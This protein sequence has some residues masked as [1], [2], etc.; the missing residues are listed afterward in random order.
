MTSK[1][2]TSKKFS[3]TTNANFTIPK[4]KLVSFPGLSNSSYA[5]SYVE[6]KSLS[7][8]YG[9]HLTGVDPTAGIYTFQDVNKDGNYGSEDYIASWNL[10][11]KFYGGMSN[12]INYQN[13]ELSFF[14]EFKKQIGFN[15]NNYPIYN[16]SPGSMYNLPVIMLQ[17]WQR[18]G[19]HANI[20]Q[21]TES[22]TP[23]LDAQYI[24]SISDGRFS[25]ASYVR[26]KNVWL[27][28]N[29]SKFLKDKLHLEN[30]RI[31]LAGQNL[32]T[33]TGYQGSDPETQSLFI[34]PSGSL[35]P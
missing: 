27:A 17:R 13:W 9:F 21:F 18:P 24:F 23:A 1:N 31:Y 12:D 26:L 11:P 25:D 10:D 32:L 19:D 16:F 6:G 35:H 4:N 14:I 34:L 2:F 20:Q 33:I 28:Y 7:T 30:F 29:F 22:Y 15:Y 5:Y 8:F 3:W